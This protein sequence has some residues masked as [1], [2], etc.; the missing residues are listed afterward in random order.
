MAL[1]EKKIFFRLKNYFAQPSFEASQFKKTV[2]KTRICVKVTQN[3]CYQPIYL[4]PHPQ[5]YI[6][7]GCHSL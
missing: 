6:M 4:Q 5:P 3:V 7:Q 2:K 1:A